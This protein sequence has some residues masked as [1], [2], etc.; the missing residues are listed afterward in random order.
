[1]TDTNNAAAVV[2]AKVEA[3]AK[4]AKVEAK[5]KVAPQAKPSQAAIYRAAKAKVERA[6]DKAATVVTLDE[7]RSKAVIKGGE[8]QA[9][10]RVYA[11]ALRK[12]FGDD[13]YTLTAAN[14]PE[15]DPETGRPS[16]DYARFLQ[17]QAEMKA[18]IAMAEA[19]GLSAP[20]APWSAA[21]AAARKLDGATTRTPRKLIIRQKSALVALYKAAMKEE[22]KSERE[23]NVNLMIGNILRTHFQV[24][25][26]MYNNRED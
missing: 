15:I 7:A 14:T 13:F 17:V 3:K 26:S 10:A 9:S 1:M 24:D 23:D 5:A 19:R 6:T 12:A 20:K 21:C 25:L 22:R 2:A 8:A 11:H 18:S 16:Q 4:R